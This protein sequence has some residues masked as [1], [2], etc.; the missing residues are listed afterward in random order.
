MKNKKAAL[1]QTGILFLVLLI[2]RVPVGAQQVREPDDVPANWSEPY[3]PFRIAGN[4]YYVGTRDLACYLV[5]T[6]KGNILIN[7]GLRGSV[8]LIKKSIETLGFRLQDTKILLTSQVHYDHV[9]AMAALKRLTGAQLMV[10]AADAPVLADGGRSD[11]AFGSDTALFEPVK[12]NRLLYDGDSIVLGDARLQLLHHPGHTKGSSSFL[13][14]VKDKGKR[15]R[16]LIANMPSIVTEKK[17]ADIP[18]YPGIAADY[19]HTLKALKDCR[20]DLWV[21]A[22]ASQFDLEKKHP[23]HGNYNPAAFADKA[24]FDQALEELTRAYE[25]KMKEERSPVK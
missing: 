5:T 2:A 6:C 16:V 22:H 14:D 13:L 18:A 7:T 23:P 12:P 1:L 20:F 4:L 11:Y 15:Y 21:A 10:N 17:F 19:A 25:K 8:A 24:G 3:P 9:G